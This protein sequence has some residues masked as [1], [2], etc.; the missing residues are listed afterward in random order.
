MMQTSQFT[1][2]EVEGMFVSSVLEYDINESVYSEQCHAEP[3]EV[4]SK[5]IISIR[6]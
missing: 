3:V 6:I 1:L 4:L 2:S 5:S